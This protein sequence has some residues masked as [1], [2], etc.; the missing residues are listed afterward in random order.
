MS[1][2]SHRFGAIEQ[3]GGFGLFVVLDVYFGERE[4][5]VEPVPFVDKSFHLIG[6]AIFGVCQGGF[7]LLAIYVAEIHMTQSY[8]EVRLC[9]EI[10][11]Q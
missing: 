9:Y 1:V 11:F 10:H 6:F 2:Y 3:G 4:A 5:R 7:A 8:T